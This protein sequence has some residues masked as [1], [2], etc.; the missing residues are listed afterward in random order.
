MTMSDDKRDGAQSIERALMLMQL[1]GRAG[2]D[3]IRLADLIAQ[4]GLVKPTARRLLLALI[5]GGLV[6]QDEVSGAISSG[7]RPICS[8]SRRVRVSAFMPCPWAG[9]R[10]L[11]WPVATVRFSRYAGTASRSVSIARKAR[12]PSARRC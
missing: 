1:V 8:G 9:C 2:Q 12:S 6:E 11:R 7:L 4:S 3:G 10:A 5:R